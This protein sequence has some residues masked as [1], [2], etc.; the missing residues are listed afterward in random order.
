MFDMYG[1]CSKFSNSLLFLF[2]TKKAVFRAEINTML[3]RMAI[4]EDPDQI[5]SSEAV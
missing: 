3:F 2:S 5:A 4:S 1:E